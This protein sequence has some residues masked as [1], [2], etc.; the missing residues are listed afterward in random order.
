M[1]LCSSPLHAGHNR[2]LPMRLSK[3]SGSPAQSAS[4][5]Q[6]PAQ[7]A[8]GTQQPLEICSFC[9]SSSSQCISRLKIRFVSALYR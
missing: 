3:R 1:H 2:S 6:P 4:L 8:I 7:R 5:V 9:A